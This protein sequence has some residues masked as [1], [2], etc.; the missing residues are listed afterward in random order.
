MARK[1]IETTVILDKVLNKNKIYLFFFFNWRFKCL[2]MFFLKMKE[3][4]F[5]KFNTNVSFNKF[6][7]Y[8]STEQFCRITHKIKFQTENV[9]YFVASVGG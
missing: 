7:L 3:I 5:Y 4:S 8:H 6:S 1:S 9:A 2:L